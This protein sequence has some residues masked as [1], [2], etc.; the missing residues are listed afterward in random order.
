MSNVPDD[1]LRQLI[2]DVRRDCLWFLRPDFYPS[3]EAERRAVLGYIERYGD[4]EA[5]RRARA[6]RAWPSPPS[7]GAS[8][9]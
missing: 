5:F 7:S 3:S 6:L 8:A 1:P 2:D 9:G 4:R